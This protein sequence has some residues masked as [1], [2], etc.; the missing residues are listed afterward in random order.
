MFALKKLVFCLL[1]IVFPV[2]AENKQE[3]NIFFSDISLIYS[4]NYNISF[5]GLEKLHPFDSK[6]YGRAM[7]VLYKRFG[8]ALD[9]IVKSPEGEIS[10]EDLLLVHGKAYLDSLKKSQSVAKVLE[11]PALAYL[12]GSSVDKLVLSPMR[13]AVAGTVLASQEALKH[14]VAINLSGGYHHAAKHH[15]EGFC[16]YSDIGVAVAVLKK[17]GLLKQNA[18][19]AI[20]DLD[21]HQGNGF[22]R[23]FMDDKNVFIFDMYNAEIYPQD[24]EAKKAITVDVPLDSG[25]GDKIYLSTLKKQLPVFFEKIRSVDLVF[26]NAGTD[27][28]KKDPLGALNISKEAVFERDKYVID[29]L[30]DR[31]LKSVML[32]SGG[33]TKESYQLVADGVAYMLDKYSYDTETI[34]N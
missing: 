32:L 26:Y 21:A 16:V 8:K 12:P 34:K 1:L 7:S 23:V 11:L 28:Y 9:K 30:Y 29:Q 31:K 3:K 5:M 25:T 20:I 14:Q 27:I 19:I 10:Q 17:Q 13:W 18:K 33:Y 24:T 6:K 2:V 15:G 22:E 4:E